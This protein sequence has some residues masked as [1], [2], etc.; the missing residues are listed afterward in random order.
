MSGVQSLPPSDLLFLDKLG[1]VGEV[2]KSV[3]GAIKSLFGKRGESNDAAHSVAD[4]ADCGAG[5]PAMAVAWGWVDRNRA[6][7]EQPSRERNGCTP[8]EA[9]AAGNGGTSA[10]EA[11]AA[12]EGVQRAEEEARA[13]RERAEAAAEAEEEAAADGAAAEEE[14]HATDNL[15]DEER[16]DRERAAL[17]ADAGH[18]SGIFDMIGKFVHKDTLAGKLVNLAG[19]LQI[20]PEDETDAERE[21]RLAAE[22]HARLVAH[23]DPSLSAESAEDQLAEIREARARLADAERSA[24]NLEH[25][26]DAEEAR[27]RRELSAAHDSASDVDSKVCFF[28]FVCLFV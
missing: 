4:A 12:S 11:L 8:G 19:R 24:T 27:A 9:G 15:T 17:D 3:H 2:V 20:A 14:E 6:G 22:E 23:A 10:E 28:F 18:S 13:E 7:G 26:A 1:K 21:A 5:K 16:E 25:T